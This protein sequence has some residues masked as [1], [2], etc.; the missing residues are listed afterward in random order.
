[1]KTDGGNVLG[2]SIMVGVLVSIGF[3][4]LTIANQRKLMGDMARIRRLDRMIDHEE[5]M[6]YINYSEARTEK[7]R[8]MMAEMNR[9]MGMTEVT[10]NVSSVSNLIN[11]PSMYAGPVTKLTN[12]I[13]DCTVLLKLA[14]EFMEMTGLTN[15]IPE[16]KWS[17]WMKITNYPTMARLEDLP[18]PDVSCLS[19]AVAQNEY[20]RGMVLVTIST[21]ATNLPQSEAV[22][23]NGVVVTPNQK[24]PQ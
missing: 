5:Q 22:P 3:G 8:G 13:P 1:M 21:N 14:K 24:E 9:L 19:N 15:N 11:Y 12:N 20:H 18:V 7:L 10:N 6:Q 4:I 17:E 23:S 16:G 2:I